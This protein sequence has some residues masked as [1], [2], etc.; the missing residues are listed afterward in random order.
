MKPKL[1]INAS[2]R[3]SGTTSLYYTLWENNYG[4]GG[5]VKDNQYL[6]FLQSPHLIESRRILHKNKKKFGEGMPR[7]WVLPDEIFLDHHFKQNELTLDNYI[8][9]YLGLWEDIKGNY[10]SLLDFSNTQEPLSEK[11]MKSVKDKLLEYFDIKFV[12]ILRDPVYR[13]WSHCNRLSIEGAGTPQ[14]LMEKNYND[15]YYSYCDQYMR[16]V[17]VWG[18]EK[19]KIIINEDFYKGKTQSLS[20]FLN[21]N[22]KPSYKDVSHLSKIKD[23]EYNSWCN[24]DVETW[25]YSM[26]NMEW[27]Y[28]EF[29]KMFGYIPD[30]WGRHSIL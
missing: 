7:P 5:G 21:W 23:S 2:Y 12:M 20:E 30:Q 10:E 8:N 28:E 9:Y 15:P 6:M 26:H 1:T 14:T 17:K 25:K 3:A 24:L 16:Y 4:H 19:I 27:V 29:E 18:E 13:L 22:I 11:F